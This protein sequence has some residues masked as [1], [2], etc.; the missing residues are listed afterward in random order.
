MPSH[1]YTHTHL[2]TPVHAPPTQPTLFT[3]NTYPLPT[4]RGVVFC[5]MLCE[6]T[7][8]CQHGRKTSACS[9]VIDINNGK[10]DART[11]LSSTTHPPLAQPIRHH[12]TRHGAANARRGQWAAPHQNI[13]AV[14]AAIAR[15]CTS[16]DRDSGRHGTERIVR[17]CS[18]AG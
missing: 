8:G 15:T 4:S 16:S 3:P 2:L 12:C 10:I 11:P 18:S 14:R 7:C 17:F 6:R 9:A 5:M 1:L 13:F